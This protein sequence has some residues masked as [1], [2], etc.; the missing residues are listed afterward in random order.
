M[1]RKRRWL[2]GGALI[3]LAALIIASFF[4]PYQI[5]PGLLHGEAFYHMQPTRYWRE[6]LRQDGGAGRI[7]DEM[8]GLFW[9]QDKSL[10]I[11]RQCVLDPDRNVRWP[12]AYHLARSAWN[13]KV[14]PILCDRFHDDDLEVRLQAIR[15]ML[16]MERKS[17]QAIQELTTVM[18]TDPEGQ[19]RHW[20]EKVLWRIDPQAAREARGWSHYVSKEWGFSAEVP[21]EPKMLEQIVQSPGGPVPAHAFQFWM[22]PSCFQII[23]NEYPK[24]FV[25]STTEE[26]RNEG[27]R[28]AFPFFF[29]GGKMT[30][31]KEIEFQGRKGTEIH[32]EVGEMGDIKQRHF[33][34]GNRMYVV[35]LIFKKEFVIREAANFFFGVGAD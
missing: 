32:A 29:M 12:A 34:V 33:W 4:E 10:P 9:E 15:G 22:E 8:D 2:L 5:V 19:A 28:K 21:A 14:V 31:E 35:M 1:T 16:R 3:V 6:R 26:E 23:V 25:A 20:A 24:D 17:P 13:P 30:S 7:S 27:L 11:L 18:K